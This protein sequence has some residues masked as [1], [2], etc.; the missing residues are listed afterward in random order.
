MEVGCVGLWRMLVDVMFV[1]FAVSCVS[2]ELSDR[3]FL[4]FLILCFVA[5][6]FFTFYPTLFTFTPV[7]FYL[8]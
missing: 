6:C 5:S 3:I 2:Y 8:G 1:E 4:G 7:I